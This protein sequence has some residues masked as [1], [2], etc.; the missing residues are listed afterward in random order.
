MSTN[1]VVRGMFGPSTTEYFDTY[2]KALEY[3]KERCN[4]WAKELTITKTELVAT[5]KWDS[6]KEKVVDASN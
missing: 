6:V 5:V 3:A 2:D 4:T 1:Y